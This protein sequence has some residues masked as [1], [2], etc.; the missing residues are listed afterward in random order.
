MFLDNGTGHGSVT[1]SSSSVCRS[2]NCTGYVDTLTHPAATD[3]SIGDGTAGASNIALK[4]VSGMT[5]TK[6]NADT[7]RFIFVSTSA[8][9]Q[10]VDSGGKTM[11]NI[12]FNGAGGSW[13]L[14]ADFTQP[15][16]STF[17][18]G[19]G[20]LD[21][22]GKT[23][24]WGFY[25]MSAGTKTLTLG[26]STINIIGASGT[27]WNASTN[28]ANWTFNANTSTINMSANASLVFA[29]NGK[30]Y[31]DVNLT[32]SGTYTMSG[33]NTF[34]NLSRTSNVS[35]S[36][37][38][39]VQNNITVSNIFTCTGT[40]TASN[41]CR[42]LLTP[43]IFQTSTA[44]QIITVNG[45]VS[46]TNVDFHCINAAGSAGT[47]TGTSLGDG[48]NNT[49]ITTDAP[50]TLY[51]VGTASNWSTL[52]RW[53]LTSGGSAATTAP[54]PQDDCKIDSAS[55]VGAS[56]TFSIGLRFFGRNIDFTGVP[57]AATLTFN[58]GSFNPAITGSVTW[59]NGMTVSS[60]AA[61]SITMWY[62]TRD[63][64][65]TSGTTSYP[66]N[67]RFVF[68]GT[69]SITLGDNLTL[70]DNLT[71]NFG[72]FNANNKNVQAL[73]FLS[74]VNNTRTLNM[75]SGT[76]TITGTGTCWNTSGTG[77]TLN[78]NTSTIV[79][80]DTSV[81]DKTFNTAGSLTFYNLSVTT[82]GTGKLIF[83]QGNTF[84]TLTQTGGST[85]TINFTAGTTTTL[86]GGASA[87]FRGASGN[88]ITIDCSTAATYTISSASTLSTDYISLKNSIGSGAGASHYAGAN[89]TDATGNTGWI[90]TAP[91]A[92]G[93]L[94]MGVG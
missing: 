11:G 70:N 69:G 36:Q 24:T 8:T 30:T 40:Y 25:A 9:V 45:S 81:T 26:A 52:N 63:V 2:L 73:Q 58:L 93:M 79:I 27:P 78:A 80:S 4:L 87:F 83:A 41:A 84:N 33:V 47:W 65:I 1:L 39:V 31:N 60:G 43:A 61:A 67:T 5:Y 21:T 15:S 64:T 51:W 68:S 56:N 59:A 66:V 90:F 18:V 54:L 38:F 6:G 34:H 85:Q 86:T 10:T 19:Q 12:F 50:R 3:V 37:A 28:A 91:P 32:G 62:D 29:G 20:T 89:S 42:I 49:G 88:L 14:A 17:N 48:G 57:N 77:L 75:G 82:G 35:G 13:Q 44:Q 46:L 74:S 94:L 55:G 53:S 92:S 16:T 76:W 23:C 22:N 7:S 72:T 71:Y